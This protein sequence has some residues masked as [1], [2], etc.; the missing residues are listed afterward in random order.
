M[1]RNFMTLALIVTLL[2][3][4]AFSKSDAADK[5]FR[6][7][8]A[9]SAEKFRDSQ[10]IEKK[11]VLPGCL[12]NQGY[13]LRKYQLFPSGNVTILSSE[14]SET[15]I[16]FSF[17]ISKK[18][19][20]SALGHV[21]A[22][23]YSHSDAPVEIPHPEAT[24]PPDIVDK[25]FAAGWLKPGEAYN[26]EV[27]P[28]RLLKSVFVRWTDAGGDSRGALEIDGQKFGQKEIG[29][30]YNGVVAR[31]P[32]KRAFST[33]REKL[34]RVVIA[35][36]RAKIYAVETVYEDYL[37]KSPAGSEA[38]PVK[39]EPVRV[40]DGSLTP[41]IIPGYPVAAET[42]AFDDYP[43]PSQLYSDNIQEMLSHPGA[44]Y[45][46]CQEYVI[47]SEL[48]KKTGISE[49]NFSMPQ[50]IGGQNLMTVMD[51]LSTEAEPGSYLP[52]PGG[53]DLYPAQTVVFSAGSTTGNSPTV[54]LYPRSTSAV[55]STQTSDSSISSPGSD[56]ETTPPGE[57]ED[58]AKQKI[59]GEMPPP[60]LLLNPAGMKMMNFQGHEIPTVNSENGVLQNKIVEPTTPKSVQGFVTSAD[61]L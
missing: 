29:S 45:L 4:A 10:S 24:T 2:L 3:S 17:R 51:D 15:E 60:P 21:T 37:E 35:Q 31:F 30:N 12:R 34:G 14:I 38:E 58:P 13:K 20:E 8:F 22:V 23:V 46:D 7:N 43:V 44:R 48:A 9:A 39:I 18:F 6:M 16:K 56:N 27:L 54:N 55:P 36:D 52:V 1:D 28:G 25:N 61:G 5:V 50:M 40:P 41:L 11:I 26:F 49:P 42:A 59:I 57:E 32:V 19:M 47:P 33:N 53:S